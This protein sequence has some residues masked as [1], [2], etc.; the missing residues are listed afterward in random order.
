[1][2]TPEFDNLKASQ[3]AARKAHFANGGTVGMWRG[4]SATFQDKKHVANKN[5][6]R[7]R[8]IGG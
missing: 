2:K 4:R 1:M 5:A 3:A 6:C 8:A 7:G